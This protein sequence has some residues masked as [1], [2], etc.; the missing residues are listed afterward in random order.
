MWIE[1]C[2]TRSHYSMDFLTFLSDSVKKQSI[3]SESLK[4]H[5]SVAPID[6]AIIYFEK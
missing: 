1:F 5:A 6:S 4:S 2:E 3:S